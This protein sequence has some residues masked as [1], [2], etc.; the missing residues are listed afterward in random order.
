MSRDSRLSRDFPTQSVKYRLSRDLP[1]QSVQIDSVGTFAFLNK[2]LEDKIVFYANFDEI[3]P[4]NFMR[5]R[6]RKNPKK[7]QG[8]QLIVHLYH[9]LRIK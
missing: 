1:T 7:K 8:R 9:N 5:D 4:L 3:Y 6:D 2:S